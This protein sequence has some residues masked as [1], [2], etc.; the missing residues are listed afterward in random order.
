MEEKRLY[1][2]IY[3]YLLTRIRYGFYPKGEYLPSIHKLSRLFG[4][5]TMAVRKAVELLEQK[6]YITS[7]GNRR[8]IVIYD[9]YD[10]QRELPESA[11][12][13]DR[14][15][16]TIHQSFDLIFPQIFYYGLTACDDAMLRELHQI[17]DQPTNAWDAPTVVFLSGITEALRNPLLLDLYYDVML[18]TYPSHLSKMAR[19]PVFW[20]QAYKKLHEKFKN[21]LTLRENGHMDALWDLVQKTYPEF[22]V[23]YSDEKADTHTDTYRWGK[24]QICHSTAKK[25]LLRIYTGEYPSQT[26]LPSARLLAEEFSIPEIT[27]R[28][29]ISLLNDL[30]VTESVNG[31]GTKVL[32]PVQSLKMIKWENPAVRKNI[33]LYLESL[34]ILTVTCRPLIC[35]AFPLISQESREYAIEEIRIAQN[36][37]KHGVVIGV[38]LMT[39]IEAAG[40]TALRRIYEKLMDLL[41]WGQTLSCMEPPLSLDHP[42][43]LLADSLKRGDS[44]QF[45]TALEQVLCT[46]FLSSQKKAVS[47][48]I[49]E[50][51]MLFLPSGPGSGTFGG[52]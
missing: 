24:I 25:L 52:H 15:L 22:P 29:S 1:I 13:S 33:A 5:S 7:S 30:G 37:G 20:E 21:L 2:L 50:A 3:G 16:K 14:E 23:V 28:R 17:L 51:A 11:F 18:F 31:V 39:L 8:T 44:L 9:A 38:C 35:T 47:I 41:I 40:L 46:T 49:E 32:S 48:G 10:P 34:H 6:G 36:T 45:G 42:A 27:M 4:V 26:F 43:E 12:L 19:D